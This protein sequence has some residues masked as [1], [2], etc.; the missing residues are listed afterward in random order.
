MIG[1]DGIIKVADFGMT[2]EANYY[3]HAATRVEGLNEEKIPIKWM[4]PESIQGRVYSESTDVWSYGVMCWEVFSGG[5]IP[6]AG[7]SPL[8]L[9]RELLEGH[10]LYRPNNAAC[11]GEMWDT[12]TLCWSESPEERPRFANLVTT[13][14]HELD[15]DPA[16]IRLIH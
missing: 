13:L 7:V 10:R 12:M 15:S 5:R 2:E 4:A 3:E 6:Y 16:Y 11:S 8:T 9:V 1:N 14:F